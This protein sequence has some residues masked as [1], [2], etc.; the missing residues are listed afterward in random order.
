WRWSGRGQIGAIDR[1]MQHVELERLTQAVRGK[2]PRRVMAAGNAREQPH[3]HGELAGEQGFQHAPLG[4][5]QHRFE[6]RR[7]VADLPPD[8]VERTEALSVDQEMRQ[9]VYPL[10]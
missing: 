9:R 5:L 2:I 1:K 4:F 3:Q 7:L 10:I 8:L 6:P